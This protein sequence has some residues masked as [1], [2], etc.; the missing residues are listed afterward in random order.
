M[1]IGLKTGEKE[2]KVHIE[3]SSEDY[4]FVIGTETY[5]VEKITDDHPAFTFS[6][7]G[8]RYPGY[9][10][11]ASNE[12]GFISID[13][14]IFEVQRLDFLPESIAPVGFESAA[15]HS[16]EIHSPMPGK[17]IR[18]FVNKGDKVAKGANLMI[19][20]A[21]KMENA[22]VSPSDGVVEVINVALNDRVDPG[23]A[24]IILKKK[25]DL[26]TINMDK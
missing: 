17:V 8:T 3:R 16:N 6:V 12:M 22:I 4:T 11:R 9:I 1:K 20:E 21:M 5:S 2:Y 13:G 19:I 14:Q 15:N 10:S 24:L 23:K 25:E 7:N 18:L 26:E